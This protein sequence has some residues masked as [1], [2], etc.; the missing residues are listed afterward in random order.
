MA[1]NFNPY[2][3]QPQNFNN[4]PYN[5]PPHTQLR[6]PSTSTINVQIPGAILMGLSV[7]WLLTLLAVLCLR[8]YALAQGQVPAEVYVKTI[9]QSISG[10]VVSIVQGFIIAGGYNMFVCGD[11]TTAKLG[12]W[13]AVIPCCGSPFFIL[14]IPFAIWGLIA[15][16]S[17]SVKR[18]FR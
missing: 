6:D 7:L 12:G 9:S 15:M 2:G 11:R 18:V 1:Q 14:G 16:D 5:R 17:E 8:V 13:L 3:F 4:G 10:V